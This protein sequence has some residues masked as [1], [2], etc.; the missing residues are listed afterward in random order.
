MNVLPGLKE[1]RA[2]E[3]RRPDLR[4]R[5]REDRHARVLVVDR[6]YTVRPLRSGD[7]LVDLLEALNKRF[8]TEHMG[9]VLEGQQTQ[10][11]MVGRRRSDDHPVGALGLEQADGIIE[12]WAT[13]SACMATASVGVGVT[14]GTQVNAVELSYGRQ[15]D[16][17]G[18]RSQADEGNPSHCA[19]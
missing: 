4:Q 6:D 16:R 17:P 5:G 11:T 8:L 1:Q 14:G 9:V 12:N 2:P 19:C 10:V 13:Q 18:G 3:A 7:D 15:V